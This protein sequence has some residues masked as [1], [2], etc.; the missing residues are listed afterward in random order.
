[1]SGL[2]SE[3][4][5]VD[6]QIFVNSH[7]YKLFGLVTGLTLIDF[8]M[9]VNFIYMLF[10]QRVSSLLIHEVAHMSL[11]QIVWIRV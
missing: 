1:M 2:A 11:T 4:A 3:L 5:L 7:L 8:Q 9:F 10:G 6:S